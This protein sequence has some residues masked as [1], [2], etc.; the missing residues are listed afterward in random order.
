LTEYATE[1]FDDEEMAVD[2]ILD[3]QLITIFFEDELENFPEGH[4][5]IENNKNRVSASASAWAKW[6]GVGFLAT[7]NY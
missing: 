3:E 5:L 2:K 7:I 4:K 1:D 6:N